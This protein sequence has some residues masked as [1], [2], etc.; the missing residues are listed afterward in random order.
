M[1][2][3]VSCFII[4][5]DEADRIGAA[6]RSVRDWVDE[7]LVVDSG[8]RDGTQAVA[9]AEGARVIYNPW[10]GFGQQKRFAEDQCRNRWVLN[11]DADEV[12]T[13]ELAAEIKA[14]FIRGE[15][16]AVVAYGMQVK[17]I[18]PGWQRPRLWGRDH[19]CLRLYDRRRVRFRDSTL[20]DSVVPGDEP[21][22]H[23]RGA[24]H[25]YTMR[26]LAAFA[27]KCNARATYQALHA[28]RRSPW[29]LRLRLVTELPACFLKYYLVRG[30]VS[31]GWMGIKVS[32]I[33]AYYR[34]A[35]IVRMYRYQAR[36][37]AAIAA[38]DGMVKG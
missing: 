11:I 1:R 25:H 35:R 27:S 17:I 15:P 12:V 8:S 31:G 29:A 38:N 32:A 37:G 23:V 18:Y 30:H 10:P 19:Y 5:Q 24:L 20:H 3:P 14:L 2:L 9:D 36:S 4:A 13:S 33:M 16:K 6:I 22:G 28:G 21:V 7:T 34:R 26:T